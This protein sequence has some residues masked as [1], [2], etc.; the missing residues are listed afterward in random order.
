M[1]K[2]KVTLNRVVTEV[3][4][5]TVDAPTTL[6]AGKIAK[7]M[8]GYACSPVMFKAKGPETVVVHMVEL[9]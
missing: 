2:F 3:A 7:D 8:V 5:V 6:T 1:A 4:T 9:A